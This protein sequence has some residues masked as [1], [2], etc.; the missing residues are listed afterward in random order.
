[1]EKENKNC[2]CGNNHEHKHE[3]DHECCGGNGHEHKHDHD[4]ECCGGHN[5]EHHDHDHECGCG[6]D[7]EAEE[8]DTMVLTLDDDSEME[9]F[10]IGS[11][12]VEDKNYIALL[13][14]NEDDGD[15]VFL[16]EYEEL[17]DKEID[18]KVIEDDAE[19]EKVS[20]EFEDLFLEE[21]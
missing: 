15:E 9:C 20:K 18:L 4:H 19:F 2:G 5:H 16:Y 21:E 14:T 11:F 8:F 3:H 6:H 17:N 10:V 12:E 1:M 13:P 7:H